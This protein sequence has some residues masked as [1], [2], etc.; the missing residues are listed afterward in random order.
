MALSREA[1][2]E[3]VKGRLWPLLVAERER[4]A[5]I[6][7]WMRWDHDDPHR[8]RHATQEYRDLAK[9][10]QA[11]W[12][13][14]V[15]TAVTDQLYVEGYRPAAAS[16]NAESWAYWQANGLD[17]R[18][19]AIHEAAV[20]Y[21]LA[22][23][24]VLPGKSWLGDRMPVIRGLDPSQMVAV[25]ADPAWDDWP[26]YALRAEGSRVGGWRLRL[27]DDE[28]VHQL[29]LSSSGDRLEYRTAQAHGQGVCPVVRFTNHLDL[30]GRADGDVDPIIPVLG[31]IDQTVFDRLV[32]QRFASWKVRYIA[33]MAKPESADDAA[34]ERLRLKVE[35]LLVA[36][37]HDTKFGTLEETQLAPFIEAH[38][39]DVRALA[40][41][42]QSPAHEL[43]GT[44]ANLSAEALA[45]AEASLTRRV[46]RVKHPL[47]EAW[48]QTLRL[49][50]KVMGDNDAAKDIASEVTWRDMESRSLAQA[51]DALGK[52]ATMLGVPVEV[53]W[54]KIPG[55]TQQDVERAKTIAA[56][57]GGLDA[58]LRELADGQTS[59]ELVG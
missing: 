38:D 31:R 16:D 27:Y 48:E 42:S 40:A 41:L 34:A 15:V 57:G 10:A 39:A 12:G 55:W 25:Y 30:R 14:R 47:G 19:I 11:P 58:L 2:V 35:D 1:A 5:R 20:G 9:R 43:V 21:G 6:D 29:I 50:A 13:R 33:G 32:V 54:E 52:L 3:V 8:P 22:Y 56:E 45:A 59:P 24:V 44:M 37:D 17:A 7:R 26:E 4:V 18:Q 51:A 36:E 28:L 46:T 23:N 49:A 53:L